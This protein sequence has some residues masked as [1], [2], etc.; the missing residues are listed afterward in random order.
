QYARAFDLAW[1]H[2]RAFR[3]EARLITAGWGVL[4]LAEAVIRI[5][6]V[7][8]SSASQGVLTGQLP[9][10]VAIVVGIVFTRLR[11]PKLRAHALR[12]LPA[13][14]PDQHTQRLPSVDLPRH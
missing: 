2:S 3:R 7:L 10:V 6:V 9:G 4:W 13:E 8:N 11:I 5:P 12:Q 1:T 14:N